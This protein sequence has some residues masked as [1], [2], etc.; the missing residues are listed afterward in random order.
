MAYGELTGRVLPPCGPTPYCSG[1]AAS[2]TRHVRRASG[3][4]ELSA[5]LEPA[6]TSSAA[7]VLQGA[8]GDPVL[9]ALVE[10]TASVAG[11]ASAQLALLTDEHVV[12]AV[13]GRQ[14][15]PLSDHGPLE[16]SLCAVTVLSGDVLVAADTRSHPWLCDVAPVVA[17]HV[18]AYLGV[19]LPACDG[20]LV[21]ALCAYDKAPREWSSREVT[22]VCQVADVVALHL[23]RLAG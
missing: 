8:A 14:P 1:V 22:L 9:G 16:G 15:S 13:G 12:V 11:S 7:A 19:P 21:G 10:L 5:L 20:A 6:R 18:G 2:S 23:R 3:L 17:G 4:P